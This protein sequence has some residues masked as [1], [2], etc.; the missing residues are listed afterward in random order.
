VTE[1]PQPTVTLAD[2]EAAR[3]VLTGISIRTPMERSRWLSASA[4]G[5]V[6][7]KCENLQRTGSFKARGAYVRISRLSEEQRAHGVVA[8]SAGNA[9]VQHLASNTSPG[10][11]PV[12]ELAEDYEEIG[13]S[14]PVAEDL[15]DEGSRDA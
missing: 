7:L 11:D 4:G 6:H 8:A 13:A 5:D 15:L 14:A 3:D 9:V 12:E 1:H 2:I 10:D